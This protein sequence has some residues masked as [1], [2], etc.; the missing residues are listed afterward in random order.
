MSESSWEFKSPPRHHI[1]YVVNGERLPYPEIERAG[2]AEQ[3]D[4]AVSKTVGGRPSCRFESDLRH[5]IQPELG[6]ELCSGSTG[7]F[8]SSSPGSNPGSAARYSKLSK[9]RVLYLRYSPVA[10]W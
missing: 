6:A 2:V 3:V 8:G 9:N 4:A 10:Q 5:H 1:E 7:D